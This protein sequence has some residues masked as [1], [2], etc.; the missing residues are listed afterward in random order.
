MKMNSSFATIISTLA[1]TV[2]ISS[3]SLS[4][5]VGFDTIVDVGFGQQ[6]NQLGASKQYDM[7]LAYLPRD[8]VID[9]SGNIY[10][11]DLPKSRV[12]RFDL[13]GKMVLTIPLP[14]D[15]QRY[16][17]L[18]AIDVENKLYVLITRGEFL[19]SL[20]K[21]NEASQILEEVT[22]RGKRP[23]G[24]DRIEG[25]SISKHGRIY[26]RTFPAEVLRANWENMT[27]VYTLTGDF[28][29]MV[30]YS[31]EGSKGDAYK[32]EYENGNNVLSRYR[33]STDDVRPTKVLEKSGGV[34]FE[35]MEA[36]PREWSKDDF[37]L[38][39]IDSLSRVYLSSQVLTRR[40]NTELKIQSE[41]PTSYELLRK[42]YGIALG[43]LAIRISPGGQVYAFGIKGVKE[44][45]Y[46]Y[47]VSEVSF[48]VL[49][50][51]ETKR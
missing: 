12:V 34:T 28:L 33:V 10:V 42:K 19:L 3:S 32:V 48:V 20:N 41:I 18:L 27:F 5:E 9:C 25:F 2:G 31:L 24:G 35:P 6:N 16:N 40:Y 36:G 49:R 46:R 23:Q 51:K 1:L 37:Y 29:G 11:V 22:L 47:G 50:F 38:T 17:V 15:K 7:A 44:G 45:E 13:H 14:H 30:D 43:H 21:L 39:G 26:I 8:V 4:Q